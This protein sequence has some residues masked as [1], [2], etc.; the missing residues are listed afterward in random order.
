M[1]FNKDKYLQILQKDGATAALT[2]LHR[3][4]AGW[5]YEAFEG[6]SGWSPEMWETIKEVRNFSR[7]LWEKATLQPQDGKT[8]H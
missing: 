1:K 4:T 2:A 6:Q 7:E 3:D 8:L 5:E